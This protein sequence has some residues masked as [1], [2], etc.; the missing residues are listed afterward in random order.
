MMTKLTEELEYL[1]RIR[2]YHIDA[3]DRLRELLY[4]VDRQIESLEITIDEE[5]RVSEWKKRQLL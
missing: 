1:K 4:V 3:I 5:D 2:K